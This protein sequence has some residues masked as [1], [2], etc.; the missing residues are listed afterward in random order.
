MFSKVE[1]NWSTCSLTGRLLKS[2]FQ[3]K[4]EILFY[5]HLIS[6]FVIPNFSIVVIFYLGFHSRTF[7]EQ[8]RNGRAIFLTPLYHFHPLYKHLN[9]SRAITAETSPLHIASNRTQTGNLWF[10]SGSCYPLTYAPSKLQM[11][12][13]KKW[14]A[15]STFRN[16]L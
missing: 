14:M 8:Q 9:I 11:T 10:P 13:L 2:L 12:S 3:L 7:T 4:R 1:F 5:T 6:L 15:D 16:K